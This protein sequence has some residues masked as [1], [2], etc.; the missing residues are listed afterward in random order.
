[1]VSKVQQSFDALQLINKINEVD[2]L[3][4]LLLSPN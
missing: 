1:M 2:K 3:K 4:M